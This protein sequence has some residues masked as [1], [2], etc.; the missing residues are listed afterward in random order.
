MTTKIVATT[1]TIIMK[2]HINKTL[3]KIRISG[4][5]Q[6]THIFCHLV[7]SFLLDSGEI[8]GYAW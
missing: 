3:P 4:F 2:N 8:I 6:F 7:F 5:F 1:T